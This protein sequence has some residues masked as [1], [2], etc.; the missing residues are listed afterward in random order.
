MKKGNIVTIILVIS[1]FVF[2][3]LMIINTKKSF[4]TSVPPQKQLNNITQLIK[5]EQP[6]NEPQTNTNTKEITSIATLPTEE[7]KKPTKKPS[8]TPN[9]FGLIEIPKE[10]TKPPAE[11][12]IL[13]IKVLACKI[14]MSSPSW[15]KTKPLILQ[16]TTDQDIKFI[17]PELS[18]DESIPIN[19]TRSLSLEPQESDLIFKILCGNNE[20]LQ[21]IEIR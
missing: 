20:L 7:P 17:I 1:V 18:V 16:I 8:S 14:N 13:K 15:P 6:K 5:P 9:T 19:N 4:Q 2:S 3:L 11:S 12:D 21:K 10:E